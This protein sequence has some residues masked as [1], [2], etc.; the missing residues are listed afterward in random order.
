MVSHVSPKLPTSRNGMAGGCATTRKDSARS[1]TKNLSL[2]EHFGFFVPRRRS[3]R[4]RIDSHLH[5]KSQTDLAIRAFTVS[6]TK[7][8]YYESPIF[9]ISRVGSL[10]WYSPGRSCVDSQTRG[11]KYR[12]YR[13]ERRAHRGEG[14]KESC[15]HCRLQPYT[16]VELTPEIRRPFLRCDCWRAE[17]RLDETQ[18]RTQTAPNCRIGFGLFRF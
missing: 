3:I 10:R 16:V 1:S 14:H 2:A 5:L 13:Q 12:N 15:S 4:C 18:F 8:T 17:L 6:A 11:E 7:F 9:S